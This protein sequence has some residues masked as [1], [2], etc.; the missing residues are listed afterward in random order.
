MKKAF[1]IPVGLLIILA[2]SSLS[3]DPA[4]PLVGRWQQQINGVTLLFNFRPDGT[5]DGFVNGKSYLTGRYYV[6]QDTIGVTD[7]KCDPTYFGT[8]R[9][10]FLVPDS[11]RFTAILDTCRDRRETVPTLAL[12][13]VTTVKP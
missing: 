5:Y 2:L 8:Y 1:I 6:H 3:M 11:V 12:G 4:N 7:G 9:L 13:R 10:Q